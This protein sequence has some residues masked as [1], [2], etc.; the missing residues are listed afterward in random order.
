MISRMLGIGENGSL[1][2]LLKNL[3]RI[4]MQFLKT[5]YGIKMDKTYY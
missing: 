5:L 3:L 1:M 4:F 2:G